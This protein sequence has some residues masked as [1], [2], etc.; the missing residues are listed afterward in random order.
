MG[1]R[2]VRRCRKCGI[3]LHNDLYGSYCEDHW[4][5][6][7]GTGD[8]VRHGA[9]SRLTYEQTSERRLLQV[10]GRAAALWSR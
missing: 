3:L 1:N 8:G 7:Q 4:A 10:S 5:D 2:D 6:R 9:V